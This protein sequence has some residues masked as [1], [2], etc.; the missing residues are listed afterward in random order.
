[1]AVWLNLTTCAE[2]KID[3]VCHRAS[4]TEAGQKS[5]HGND[6]TRVLLDWAQSEHR[7]ASRPNALSVFLNVSV[8]GHPARHAHDILG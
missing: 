8:D 1:M 3:S 4:R 6:Y 5:K 2:S 7:Q